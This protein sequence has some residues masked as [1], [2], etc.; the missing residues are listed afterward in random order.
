M[1]SAASVIDVA[2]TVG[3]LTDT[4]GMFVYGNWLCAIPGMKDDWG[5]CL[6]EGDCTCEAEA[7]ELGL[8]VARCV[9]SCMLPGANIDKLPLL[10]ESPPCE[11]A[12]SF[13]FRM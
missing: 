2:P 8:D 12:P 9:A 11:S 7:T 6:T 10:C 13:G 1:L 4:G 5:A 3:I